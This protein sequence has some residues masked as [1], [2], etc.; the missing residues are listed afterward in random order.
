M[1]FKKLTFCL[2]LPHVNR[3]QHGAVVSCFTLQSSLSFFSLDS[4]QKS[5]P[6][7]T[8]LTFFSYR[9]QRQRSL[10]NTLKAEPFSLLIELYVSSPTMFQQIILVEVCALYLLGL[11]CIL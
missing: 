4:L 7:F 8:S 9:E 1:C 5:L 2:H 11:H 6:A 3:V 10:I